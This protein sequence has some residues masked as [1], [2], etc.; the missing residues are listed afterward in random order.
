V[1]LAPW[2]VALAVAALLA[3]VAV[4]RFLSAPRPR[5]TVVSSPAVAVRGAS[6]ARNAPEAGRTLEVPTEAKPSEEP[7]KEDGVDSALKAARE[8]ARDRLKR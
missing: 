1:A 2:L 4:R 7:A 3:E 6:P 8:R 5:R